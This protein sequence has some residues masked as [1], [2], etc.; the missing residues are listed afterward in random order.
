MFATW[1]PEKAKKRKRKVPM[2]SPHMATKW[3]RKCLGR[4]L[5]IGSR[6]AIVE[7][8][9][10]LC[11]LLPLPGSTKPAGRGSSMFMM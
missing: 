11:R 3:D 6:L 9:P 5:R 4:Y 1:V 10:C 7:S 8:V 2:N